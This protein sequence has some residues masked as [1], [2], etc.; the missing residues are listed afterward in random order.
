MADNAHQA[1]LAL[2]QASR[3]ALNELPVDLSQRQLAI[4]LAIYM[5]EPPH[6]VSNLAKSLKISKPAI[7]RALDVLSYHDMIRRKKDDADRRIVY[8][9][10]TV[11]GSVYLR[12]LG[13][14]YASA[15]F[16]PNWVNN[17]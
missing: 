17:T 6:T 14:I 12:D 15:A 10:R 3:R 9:Q 1:L 16:S 7:C 13:E 4:L 8:L 2:Y 5:G 11:P